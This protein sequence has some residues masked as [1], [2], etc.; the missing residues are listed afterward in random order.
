MEIGELVMK[1]IFSSYIWMQNGVKQL[2]KYQNVN[3]SLNSKFYLANYSYHASCLMSCKICKH[4]A[5]LRFHVIELSSNQRS[6][7]RLVRMIDFSI[8]MGA[9]KHNLH[10]Y[11]RVTWKRII[12]IN[13]NFGNMLFCLYLLIHAIIKR[14]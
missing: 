2:S 10:T 5:R 3:E 8:N 14:C 12:G 7:L 9:M 6:I 11:S 1:H 4:R 13:W